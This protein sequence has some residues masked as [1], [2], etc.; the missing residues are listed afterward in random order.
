MIVDILTLFPGYFSSP[1]K[2]GNLNRGVDQGRVQIRI[3][4]LR[5]F[6]TDRHRTVDDRP[7]GGGA[8][9]I[10]K[11][12]PI[13]RALTWLKGLSGP[14]P[15]VILFS[16]QGTPLKQSRIKELIQTPRITLICGKYEGIDERI[17]DFFCDEQL[18]IGDYIL[19]GGEAAALVLLDTLVRLVPGVMGSPDSGKEESFEIGLLEYPQYTRPRN[20][21]GHE[22]PDVLLSGDHERIRDW[23]HRRSLER[24]LR[25]RPNLIQQNRL[26]PEDRKILESF[27]EK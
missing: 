12:E 17:A 20:F 23:R 21:K 24:T 25:R 22:V 13:C 18:S 5:D 6:S 26:S 15:W 4:N 16:P 14:P 7:F 19:S 2:E 11:P 8:G 27:K 10:L 3:F 9:M 1:I